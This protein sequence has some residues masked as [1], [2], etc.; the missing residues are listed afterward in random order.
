M[1]FIKL[2]LTVSALGLFIAC[3]SSN[4]NQTTSVTTQ[5]SPAAPA[6]TP[7]TTTPSPEDELAVAR[8]TFS[9]VCA[10]CHKENGEGG[11]F[12]LEGVKLKVPNLRE[13]HVVKDSDKELA[14]QIADG[15]DGMP[16]F[17]KR[18]SQEQ[19]DN[20]VRFIRRDLQGGAA[21]K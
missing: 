19:I 6:M 18:L 15:G 20:L 2:A 8:A 10:R 13:G 4:T 16:A 12:E 7:T 17:K 1:K 5:P 21:S 14:E 9:Q 3:T 11:A